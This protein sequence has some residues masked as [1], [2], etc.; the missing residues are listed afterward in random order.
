MKPVSSSC[1]VS[2]WQTCLTCMR[3]EFEGPLHQWN[4]PHVHARQVCH[5]HLTCT[6]GKFLSHEV[7]LNPVSS[8]REVSLRWNLS[9]LTCTRDRFAIPASRAREVSLGVPST[10]QTHLAWTR[11]GNGKPVSRAREVSFRVKPVSSSR[12]VTRGEFWVSPLPL[13]LTSRARETGLAFSSR[14]HARWV[15]S[16]YKREFCKFWSFGLWTSQG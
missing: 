3:G 14:M 1:K 16:L 9:H 10:T 4:S 11:G 7:S 15:W 6:R 12:E 5:S 8:S 2:L 13:R